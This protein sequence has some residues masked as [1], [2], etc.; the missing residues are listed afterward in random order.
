VPHAVESA[1]AGR[2]GAG[3]RPRPHSPGRSP[4]AAGYSRVVAGALVS[5]GTMKGDLRRRV[6]TRQGI[7]WRVNSRLVG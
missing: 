2:N 4:A 1:V 3:R 5:S 6:R 7:S